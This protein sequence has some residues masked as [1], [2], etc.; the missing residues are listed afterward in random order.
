VPRLKTMTRPNGGRAAL[1]ACFVPIRS[2]GG[3]HSQTVGRC[4]LACGRAP[5][6]A[7]V[8]PFLSRTT[9][10]RLAHCIAVCKQGPPVRMPGMDLRR[11]RRHPASSTCD[12]PYLR[13]DSETMFHP[14][15]PQ[16]KH[17]FRIVHRRA[18][19]GAGPPGL[20]YPACGS[21]SN[22]VATS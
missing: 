17:K 9:S 13:L 14:R 3:R 20:D 5:R 11:L 4:L 21:F 10:P 7:A 22:S 19:P 16:L 6:S 1:S 8:S 2:D 15:Y 18:G 12:C